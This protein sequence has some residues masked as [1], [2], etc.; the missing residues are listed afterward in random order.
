MAFILLLKRSCERQKRGER[1][2]VMTEGTQGPP[3]IVKFEK[4]LKSRGRSIISVVGLH[5][6]RLWELRGDSC[7]TLHIVET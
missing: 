6:R 2:R 3:I 5:S 1:G 4:L 7:R